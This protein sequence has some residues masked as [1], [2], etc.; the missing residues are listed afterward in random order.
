MPSAHTHSPFRFLHTEWEN[1]GS[2]RPNKTAPQSASSGRVHKQ[3]SWPP[4]SVP[5]EQAAGRNKLRYF[6]IGRTL[7]LMPTFVVLTVNTDVLTGVMRFRRSDPRG[8]PVGVLP[9][10]EEESVVLELLHK[11]E[12]NFPSLGTSPQTV[13]PLKH[14]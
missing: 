5:D 9:E 14:I 12:H 8:S 3:H 1:R 6:K 2:R 11:D 4:Q 7:I 13:L 10:E